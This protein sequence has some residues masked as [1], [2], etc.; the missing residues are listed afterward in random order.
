M[1]KPPK[2]INMDE[3]NI[4]LHRIAF[5]L[6]KCIV[7][8]STLFRGQNLFYVLKMIFFMIHKMKLILL[9]QRNEMSFY[10]NIL[11]KLVLL[12]FVLDR[13]PNQNISVDEIQ[14]FLCHLMD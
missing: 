8:L 5:V 3:R 14:M 12:F 10:F 6:R 11:N 1:E 13:K 4:P 2:N 9:S 7:F